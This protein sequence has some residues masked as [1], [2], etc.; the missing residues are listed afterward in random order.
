MFDF[1]SYVRDSGLQVRI[2]PP[3]AGVLISLEVRDPVTGFC[4]CQAIT[5]RDAAK[6]SNIDKYTGAVLDSMAARI[7][8]KCAKMYA[9]RHVSNQMQER[10]DFFRGK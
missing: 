1:I 3:T 2:L 5:D 7:G 4:E 10:E 9:N 6:C 8:A